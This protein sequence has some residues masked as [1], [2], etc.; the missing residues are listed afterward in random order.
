MSRENQENPWAGLW[1]GLQDF[2]RWHVDLDRRFQA[3]FAEHGP[4]IRRFLEG[5]NEFANELPVVLALSAT[6]FHRGGWSEV[7]LRHM[8][9]S[10]FTGLVER[11]LKKH[12]VSEEELRQELDEAIGEHFRRDD[13]AALSGMVGSWREHFGGR[14]H[15]FEDA[16]W[17]HRQGRYTLSMPALA[18][19]VEGVVRDLTLEYGEGR[20]WI[21]HFNKAFGLDYNP[22]SPPKAPSVEEVAAEFRTL[23]FYERHDRMEE[24]STH[25]TL[26]RI[27]EL[28]DRGE[29]TDEQFAS[30]VRRHPILHG[31]YKNFGELQS[32]RLFFV[33]GLL[34]E[35]VKDYKERVW[36][37]PAGPK[38]LPALRQWQAEDPELERRLSSFYADGQGW[39]K[40]LVES[41]G[42]HEERHG[43]IV[44]HA[45]Q[46]VGLADLDVEPDTE[47]GYLS[48]YV[49]RDLRN[50][51]VGT[52]A[53]RRVL[54]EAQDAGLAGVIAHTQADNEPALECL[55]KAG[56]SQRDEHT[57][58]DRWHGRDRKLIL[59]FAATDNRRSEMEEA[60]N[61]YE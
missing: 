55:K 39:V 22:G 47:L 57:P 42:E 3:W 8:D 34:H 18:A 14:H 50:V 60:Q 12:E 6:L 31:V 13:H 5:V 36:L 45:G 30:S 2:T 44:C 40:E 20:G 46:T 48:V 16:L 33:L 59:R 9:L 56:F 7:P 41:E 52:A 10:E 43:W 54:R 1:R 19:Q 25:L 37:V 21:R 29:F 58:P 24:L 28:Y 11:L 4:A 32:L 38:H 17:A 51:G 53:V 49:C 15:I 26:L 61:G 35:A 27:N 23:P